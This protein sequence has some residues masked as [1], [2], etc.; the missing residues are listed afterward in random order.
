VRDCGLQAAKIG[1]ETIA[2]RILQ[3]RRHEGAHG[4]IVGGVWVQPAGVDLGLADGLDHVGLDAPD[5]I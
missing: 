2:R 1:Q 3:N 4:L 5:K